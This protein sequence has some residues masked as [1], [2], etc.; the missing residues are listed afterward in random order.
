MGYIKPEVYQSLCID[1][2]IELPKIFIETGT[3]K[4]GIPLR[5]LDENGT[6]DPFEKI[7]T[8]ELG[9][10]ICKIASRR[11][12]LLEQGPVENHILHT[13]DMDESFNK[14]QEYF[15]NRLVL[16]QDDS[17]SALQKLLPTI[18]EPC[19]FW[20][21][22][23]AGAAKY[24]KGDEDCPLLQELDI[25][26]EHDIKTH[27]IAIDDSHMLGTIQKGNNGKVVCDY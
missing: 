10:D 22:A 15:D 4:G 6:L 13:D 17:K 24:A 23:H 27:V 1:A 19:C 26:A 16:I 25:I 20:L 11:Y 21:D 5:M 9:H 12:K 18:N 3:F 8:I 2:N 14:V 7:Y